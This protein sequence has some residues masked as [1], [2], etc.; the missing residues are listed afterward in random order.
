MLVLCLFPSF[1]F[2]SLPLPNMLRSLFFLLDF[3]FFLASVITKDFLAMTYIFLE[4]MPFLFCLFS[5]LGVC[6]FLCNSL[7]S[8][9]V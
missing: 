5:S 2:P 9:G 3:S 6:T 7:R 1:Y 8:L 4:T